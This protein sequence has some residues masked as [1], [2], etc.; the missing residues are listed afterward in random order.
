MYSCLANFYSVRMIKNTCLY[1]LVEIEI[2]ETNKWWK[3]KT[4][5]AEL[6]RRLEASEEGTD[7]SFTIEELEASIDK[8]RKKA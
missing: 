1:N 3:D 8:L 2:R 5:V 6:D 7:K 4:F